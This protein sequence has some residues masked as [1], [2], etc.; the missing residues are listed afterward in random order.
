M[1]EVEDLVYE[2]ILSNL[3]IDT[4]ECSMTEAQERG[5]MALFGEKY[6]DQV[7]VVSVPGFSVELCGGTHARQ[8]GDIGLFR[9][10]SESGIAAGV[11]RIEAVTGRAAMMWV[12]ERDQALANA[13]AELRVAPSGLSASIQ[14][15]QDDRKGLEKTLAL[16]QRELARAQAGDLS[17]QARDLDG[18]KILAAEFSG[19]AGSLREEADRLRDQLGSS[20]VVLG[21]RTDDAVKLVITVSK[22]LAGTRFHAGK[23]IKS[24]AAKVGGGGGGRPDMAQAGGRKPE[25]LPQ[26]L[27]S[28]YDLI[29]ND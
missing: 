21:A 15:I 2:Q 25:A 18:V 28:V 27:E 22:D 1:V 24:V 11:R 8:T 16:T 4:D 20:V 23:L 5:A 9:I 6:G 17:D 19:D 3:S 26:A 14:R 7:R 13:C 29:Q 10:T 12:R